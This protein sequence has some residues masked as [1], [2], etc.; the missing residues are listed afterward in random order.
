MS[1]KRI[2]KLE[3]LLQVLREHGGSMKFPE[4]FNEFL[5][6][7][8]TRRTFWEYLHVLRAARKIDYNTFF[9]YEEK[10]EIKLVKEEK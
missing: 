3:Y 8:T 4:L 10:L 1:T 7:G 9:A 6:I 2:E 5:A